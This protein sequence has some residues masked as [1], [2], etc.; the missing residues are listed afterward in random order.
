MADKGLPKKPYY[1]IGEVASH[2]GVQT[3]VLRYWESELPQ[4]KPRRS[5]SGHRIYLPEDLLLLEAVN[6]MVHE[7]GLTLAGARRRL[8]QASQSPASTTP[9]PGDKDQ[10]LGELRSILKLLD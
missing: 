1:R 4:I 9:E 7:E 6:Q 10:V 8:V 5:P 2:L 3:H